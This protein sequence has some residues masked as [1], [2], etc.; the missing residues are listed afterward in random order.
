MRTTTRSS[1][2]L[3]ILPMGTDVEGHDEAHTSLIL[4]S[5]CDLAPA[6]KTAVKQLNYLDTG[7]QVT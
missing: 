2:H 6:M 5:Y 7:K 3:G 1:A 4:T